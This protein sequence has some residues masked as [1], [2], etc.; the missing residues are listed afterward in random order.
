MVYFIFICLEFSRNT[1]WA[2]FVTHMIFALFVVSVFARTTF[3]DPG[4]FPVALDTEAQYYDEIDAPPS[5]E[6]EV[7]ECAV[8]TKWCSTCR[9]Y[10]L[11]R[12]THCSTC[13]KCVEPLKH[14]TNIIAIVLMT[15]VGMIF[16][17][18]FSLTMFHVGILSKGLTTNEH[19]TKKFPSKSNPYFVGCSNHWLQLCCS[20][21]Y[22]SHIDTG[23]MKGMTKLKEM[24]RK[25]Y[26]RWEVDKRNDVALGARAQIHLTS[27]NGS[28]FLRNAPAG[29]S[30]RPLLEPTGD[31]QVEAIP[32]NK[33]SYHQYM[34]NIPVVVEP[35]LNPITKST[36]GPS[37]H[38]QNSDSRPLSPS[39]W[40]D[41]NVVSPDTL[42]SPI[43]LRKLIG[44][45][46][47]V[48]TSTANPTASA[49]RGA[50]VEDS[51]CLG[52]RSGDDMM[53]AYSSATKGPRTEGSSI[54]NGASVDTTSIIA[55][56]AAL[57]TPTDNAN[58]DSMPHC[59]MCENC[60]SGASSSVAKV[61]GNSKSEGR[62]MDSVYYQKGIDADGSRGG[63]YT[64]SRPG[65]IGAAILPSTALV[66]PQNPPFN[67]RP[68]VSSAPLQL[69]SAWPYD[70]EAASPLDAV[71][72]ED[73]RFS[74]LFAPRA[75][76][77]C[78]SI[79]S[80]GSYSS[81]SASSLGLNRHDKFNPY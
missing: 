52:V 24:K 74:A 76:A 67:S 41:K 78:A 61:S 80:L 5:H 40:S 72:D 4:Y 70:T 65:E 73:R 79:E 19:V 51:R 69:D 35:L 39:K 27:V 16:L 33:F 23:S 42:N 58:R 22:P 14:Y 59:N 21:E 12:S 32:G 18:V 37:L 10:R 48:G 28:R 56:L 9:F 31:D 25:M 46:S 77:P 38:A 60:G 8:I 7:R 15:L 34:D 81:P 13:D 1:S 63:S 44:D 17:P 75:V 26:K 57:R 36:N 47:S 66:Q 43:A 62:N 20:S 54:P 68:F 64:L 11:P 6:Y 2:I 55:H 30:G 49:M 53:Q 50:A 71:C 3:M 29:A 45:D